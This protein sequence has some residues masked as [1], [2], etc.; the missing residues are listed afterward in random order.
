MMRAITQQQ[1]DA[2][3]P[4]AA[5]SAN[6]RKISQKGGFVRL[7]R[8]ADDT[9]Y[10]GECT[11]SGKSNYITSADFLDSAAP[12]FRCT[13][14]G[15][16]IPCFACNPELLPQLLERAFRGR[17]SVP[18]RRNLRSGNSNIARCI[19]LKV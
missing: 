7:E 16:G 5:A 10:L 6:G 18:S 11:G 14:A 13:C 3:A 4:N 17:I 19:Y 15:L 2:L 9:F 12:V 8:S 1:I